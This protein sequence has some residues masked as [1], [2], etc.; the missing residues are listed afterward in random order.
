MSGAA[1]AR[2]IRRIAAC[3]SFMSV[4]PC[5]RQLWQPSAKS[6]VVLSGAKDRN[7]SNHSVS[8]PGGL[9]SW[10]VSL[11]RARAGLPP[12]ENAS[13]ARGQHSYHGSEPGTSADGL[14]L[15]Q[16]PNLSGS[17]VKGCPFADPR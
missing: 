10:R 5:G 4:L 11:T 2:K 8:C 1:T 9:K 17:T 13:L 7:I 3:I 12:N 14:I 16:P 15:G 6:L